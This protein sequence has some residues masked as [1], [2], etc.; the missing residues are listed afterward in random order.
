[1]KSARLLWLPLLA[2]PALLAT[3]VAK[4]TIAF[5]PKDGTKL[6]KTYELTMVS[7]LDDMQALMNG[8][9]SPMMPSMEMTTTTSLKLVVT[10]EY[11]SVKDGAPR[12]LVRTFDNLDHEVAMPMSMEMMGETMEVDMH[13]TGTSP[14]EGKQVT[15]TWDADA[16]VYKKAY[17]EGDD[18]DV[19]L[20]DALAEDMDLRAFL[21]SGAVAE[22]DS[23]DVEP[24]AV[25]DAL[26]PGGDLAFHMESDGDEAPMGGGG[27]DSFPPPS[28]VWQDLDGSSVSAKFAGTREVDG[29]R[30]AVIEIEVELEGTGDLTD[31]MAEQIAEQMPEG[32][33][34]EVG[35]AD[36]ESAIEA[37]GELLW[38]LSA[39][40]AV[41]LSFEGEQSS[42]MNQSFSVAFGG[43]SMEIE[44]TMETSGELQFKVTFE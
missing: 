8:E 10:D 30:V 18:G 12:K 35:G 2:S 22:G 17:P 23:W 44:Q 24:Q 4:E 41:S 29:Q 20:L 38:N 43:D 34:A 11:V 39:G 16:G 40:H 3:D 15:F 9:E 14:L 31:F 1:M 5:A 21:P 33:E 27:A 25:L 42:I 6:T 13:A 32:I 26:F 7:E 19:D 37:K 28:A 36:V